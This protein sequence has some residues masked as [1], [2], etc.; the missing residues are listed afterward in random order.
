[1][2]LHKVLRHR[3]Q[4]LAQIKSTR[5]LH[6]D[7]KAGKPANLGETNVANNVLMSPLTGLRLPATIVDAATRVI[8]RKREI[9]AELQTELNRRQMEAAKRGE[10]ILPPKGESPEEAQARLE[11]LLTP[12]RLEKIVTIRRFLVQKYRF[13]KGYLAALEAHIQKLRM[14]Q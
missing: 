4:V 8:R 5:K 3:E 10:R 14:G 9:D 2:E 6:L 12:I 11:R 1:M 13:E 7:A